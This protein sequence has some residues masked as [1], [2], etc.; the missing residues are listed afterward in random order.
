MIQWKKA[1]LLVLFI[2]YCLPASY[3]LSKPRPHPIVI[4]AIYNLTGPQSILDIYSSR[5]AMLAVH[6]INAA[7]GILGSPLELDLRDGKTDT[8][9]IK[10]EAESFAYKKA[11]IAVI[12][13]SNA[14]MALAAIPPLASNH[15][16]FITSGATSPKLPDIAPGWVFL[17]SF[18][19]D[20]Q[21]YTAAAFAIRRLKA[22]HALLI[23]QSDNPFVQALS[24]FFEE[25]YRK[26]GGEI[27]AYG[28][29]SANSPDIAA[30]LSVLKKQGIA[31]DIIYLAAGPRTSLKII[32]QLRN[33]GFNQ[34]IM[35]CDSLD[36]SGLEQLP[37]NLP[38]TLYFT[39]HAF[40]NKANPDPQV[41]KF[42]QAY[43]DAW[44]QPP[45]SGF[46]GLGYDT[47]RLLAQAISQAKSTDS[48]QIRKA[49]LQT[50]NFEGVTGTMNY[51]NSP[52]PDKS[53]TVMRF[54]HG[55]RSLA[56]QY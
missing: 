30:E 23:T 8:Q 34:P 20:E 49:L 41:Q 14:N 55:Q 48:A 18:P 56:V 33:A 16:L 52:I 11:V 29:Y 50:R 28:Q 53:I 44:Q 40:I 36:S 21:A 47:V 39:S 1:F 22:T 43:T 31:P 6:E 5:G 46:S 17:A 3:A 42:I 7:G 27:I 32:M 51:S 2:F 45:D 25:S 12:G 35:A 54:Q 4:G 24:Q 9:V 13:L 26:L 19:D 37:K 10:E 15:K 38:G